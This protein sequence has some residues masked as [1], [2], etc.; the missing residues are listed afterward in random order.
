MIPLH[1]SFKDDR[2]KIVLSLFR[3]PQQI[4]STTELLEVLNAVENET[5]T[6][7]DSKYVVRQISHIGYLMFKK[8]TGYS[9]NVIDGGTEKSYKLNT[10]TKLTP[11]EPEAAESSDEEA[12]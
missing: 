1:F 11:V 10:G 2:A 9:I 6:P 7:R 3:A 12:A 4:M 8:Q 5:G